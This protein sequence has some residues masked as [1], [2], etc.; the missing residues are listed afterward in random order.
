MKT[1]ATKANPA[2]KMAQPL[3]SWPVIVTGRAECAAAVSHARSFRTHVAAPQ[4]AFGL[5]L[6]AMPTKLELCAASAR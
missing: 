5:E 6:C 4:E 2:F 1:F 3:P